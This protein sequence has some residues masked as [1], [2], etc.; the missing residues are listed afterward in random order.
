M[1]EISDDAKRNREDWTQANAAYTD[2]RASHN[3][4]EEEI[5]W[6]VFGVPESVA[7][8][9][10]RRRRPRRR[11]ARLRH[12]VR[13][14]L[15]RPTRRPPGRRRRDAGPAR[16]GP[17]L[18]GRVRPRLPARR[19][20]RRGRATAV[21]ELRPRRLGVRREHLVRPASLDPRGASAAAPGWPAVVPA[22]Q[23]ARD[24]LR[25]GRRRQADRSTPPPATGARAPRVA[26]RARRRVAA[27]ARRAVP[28]AA[29][30]GVRRR[31]SRRALPSRR[32]RR[33]HVLRD[34]LGR[35]GAQVACR[36]DLGREEAG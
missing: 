12:G 34:V 23:H 7:R 28:P 17:P 24:P 10:R 20:E 14:R 32:R 5:S 25:A 27:P 35:V 29:A 4:A 9:P 13:L 16:D 21:G 18:P 33:S 26:R 15:A 2:A 19:G 1:P 11:R 31:R 3:W 8:H 30:N 36:G 6:G 22:Q